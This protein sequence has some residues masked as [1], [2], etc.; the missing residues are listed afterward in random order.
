M[1]SSAYYIILTYHACGAAWQT[2]P[3]P[4]KKNNNSNN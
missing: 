2:L 1:L 3:T 4:P